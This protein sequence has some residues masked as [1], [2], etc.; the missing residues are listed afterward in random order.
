M[1]Y[2]SMSKSI[3][4]AIVIIVI[5]VLIVGISIFVFGNKGSLGG[6]SGLA[7]KT[8]EIQGMKVEVLREGSGE[9]AK[10]GNLITTHYVGTLPD[11][12]EFD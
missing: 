9:E 10:T 8:F 3:L 11:G 1:I 7:S 5:V 2:L 12:T 4:V 6:G